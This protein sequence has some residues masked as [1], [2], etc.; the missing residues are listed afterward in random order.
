MFIPP[1]YECR[2]R[3]PGDGPNP[4]VALWLLACVFSLLLLLFI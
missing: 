3:V 4:W 1:P 2:P